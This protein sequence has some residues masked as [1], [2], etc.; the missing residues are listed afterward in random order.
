MQSNRLSTRARRRLLA[1]AL[2]SNRRLEARY[3]RALA[4]VVR[5]MHAELRAAIVPRLP[6]Y[7]RA[8]G[9]AFD[10]TIDGILV[11]HITDAARTVGPL[12]ERH[13]RDVAKSNATALRAI[14]IKPTDLRLG[15]VLANKR[16]ENIRLIDKTLRGS[17]DEIRDILRDPETFGLRVEEIAELL[18]ERAK[19]S[20]SRAELIARDQTTKLNGAINQTRQENAGVTSYVWSTS[21]DERVRPEHAALEGRTFS[22]ND[23]PAVGHPGEDIQ[24]RCVALPVLDELAGV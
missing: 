21:N 5:A 15:P 11:R 20:E 1:R 13:A 18:A 7:V 16:E 22:W 14:G 24:C 10:T 17:A 9:H 2:E 4:R 23:P 8:D 3:A 19:V 6:S 12:F